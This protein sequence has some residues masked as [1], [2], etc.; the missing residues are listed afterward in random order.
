VP[1]S[2]TLKA[3]LVLLAVGCVPASVLRSFGIDG[4]APDNARPP[5]PS[6]AA[7][8]PTC[9]KCLP[10]VTSAGG[11]GGLGHPGGRRATRAVDEFLMGYSDLPMTD[12]FGSRSRS[13]SKMPRMVS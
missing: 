10:L 8:P 13:Q 11:N 7:T 4:R 12:E 6:S 9:L 5:T 2:E 1:G 3:D